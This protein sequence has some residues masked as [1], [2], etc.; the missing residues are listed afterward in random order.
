MKRAVVVLLAVLMCLS[1]ACCGKSETNTDA[2]YVPKQKAEIGYDY[3]T[4]MMIIGT[5]KEVNG[6]ALL[7]VT[8]DGQEYSFG[9]SDKVKVVEDEYYVF[10]P[11]ASDL[12][13]KKVTAIAG[14]QVQETWPMGLTNERLIIIAE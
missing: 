13:G 11:K 5:V 3:E 2:T 9:F 12:A 7:I 10:R 1:F 14:N 6:N 8:D 4:E